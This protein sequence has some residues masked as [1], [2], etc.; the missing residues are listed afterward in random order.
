MNDLTPFTAG[1]SVPTEATIIA[2]LKLAETLCQTSFVPDSFRGKAGETLAAI[3]YGAELGI[4]PMTALQQIAVIKGKPAASPELM[5]ALIRRAGHSIEAVE[6]T[7]ETCTLRGT[8]GDDGVQELSTF[9]LEDAKRASLLNGGA[10]KSYPKAMLLARATSQ[11]GRSL[12]ADV[13]SGISYTPEELQAI[14]APVR[15]AVV[16][17]SGPDTL[18]P[19]N[20][21][22]RQLVEACGG[23]VEQAKA[24]W[25]DR[26]GE[27]ITQG[28]LDEI[29][30][31]ETEP[32]E[33]DALF[34]EVDEVIVDAELVTTD[35]DG[36]VL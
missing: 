34:G 26:S 17:E 28:E 1:P 12:F 9:T 3:L 30:A 35:A 25:G 20:A 16:V 5:R 31:I 32:T 7:N 11:L 23:D 13:I 15:V 19:G 27:F 4:G 21:A 36:E 29:L 24:I 33:A 10:W 2:S 8:R 6:H 14:D 22:K 18:V